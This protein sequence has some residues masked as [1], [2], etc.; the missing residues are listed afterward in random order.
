MGS[1]GNIQDERLEKQEMKN[2]DTKLRILYLSFNNPYL[3]IGVYKKEIEFCK[4][5]YEICHEC[6][7]C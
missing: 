1:G 4:A 3:T 2:E 7:L 6:G 5:M